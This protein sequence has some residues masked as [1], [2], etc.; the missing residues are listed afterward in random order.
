MNY[1]FVI[2]YKKCLFLEK[3]YLYILLRTYMRIF[4]FF[5]N[6]LEFDFFFNYL[7]FIRKE[8]FVVEMKV[9]VGMEIRN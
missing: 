7:E 2:N 4:D 5:F 3:F 1:F 8:V 9:D 6:Y